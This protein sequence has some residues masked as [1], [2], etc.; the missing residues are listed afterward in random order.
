[1][2]GYEIYYLRP[3]FKVAVNIYEDIDTHFHDRVHVAVQDR[4]FAQ[5]ISFLLFNHFIYLHLFHS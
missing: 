3:I 2:I 5:E 4:Y 1:M